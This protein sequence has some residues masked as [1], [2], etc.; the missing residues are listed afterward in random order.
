MPGSAA[1]DFEPETGTGFGSP[2]A[3][4]FEPIDESGNSLHRVLND[5]RE[6][7]AAAGRYIF[8][9]LEGLSHE[10]AKMLANPPPELTDVQAEEVLLPAD[11]QQRRVG[12]RTKAAQAAA[13]KAEETARYWKQRADQV[14]TESGIDPAL[15]QTWDA[16]LSRAAGPATGMVMESLI[17]F[18]GLPIMAMHG[19]AAAEAEAKNAG[20]TDEESE[21]AAVRSLIGLGIFGGANKV[22]ALGVAKLLPAGARTVTKFVSQFIGQDV[23]NE[24]SSR[25]INAWEA[26]SE[27][28]P[29]EKIA[30]ATKALTNTTLESTVLNGVY[31]TMGAAHAAGRVEPIPEGKMIQFEPASEVPSEQSRP[32]VDPNAVA[33]GNEAAARAITAIAPEDASIIAGEGR[34]SPSAEDKARARYYVEL[35]AETDALQGETGHEILDAVVKAGGLPSKQGNFR[36]SYGGE[37]DSL[38]EAFRDPSLKERIPLNKVFR[39]DAPSADELATRLRDRGFNVQSRENVT[40]L[41]DTRLRTGRPIFGQ[42]AAAEFYSPKAHEQDLHDIESESRNLVQHFQAEYGTAG[43]IFR[44]AGQAA[45]SAEIATGNAEISDIARRANERSAQLKQNREALA[46]EIESRGSLEEVTAEGITS[47]PASKYARELIA[48]YARDVRSGVVRSKPRYPIYRADFEHRPH[49][50]TLAADYALRSLQESLIRTGFRPKE[51]ILFSPRR[52]RGVRPIPPPAV[53]PG[54]VMTM[55]GR[56]PVTMGRTRAGSVSGSEVMDALK[57][58]MTTSG[59]A[60]EIRRGRFRTSMASGIFKSQP[61]IVRL[62]HIDNIPTAVHE[63]GHA[64]MKQFYG[65][66]KA[67]GLKW[68]P[69]A[70]RREL[71]GMGKEL[72]GNRKP[73]AGYSGEGFA[74]FIRYYLTTD[75]AAKVAPNTFKFFEEGVLVDHPEVATQL[76]AART[77]I[78]IY[79]NQGAVERANRQIVRDPGWTRRT[80]GALR[81]FFTLQKQVE[82]GVPLLE[83]SREAHRRSG[84]ALSPSEDPYKLFKMKRGSSG[85][86]M[87]RMVQNNMVD[88]WGNPTGP[89]LMEALAEVKGERNEFLLYLFARRAQERWSK[90][91]NPGI[92]KEDADYIRQTLESQRFDRAAVKYYKWWD[93]VLDYLAQADPAMADITLQIKQGSS[94]YAPLARML[95]ESAVRKQ[96]AMSQINP[97]YRMHGS[98]LPVKDIFDQTLLSATRLVN[99]ANRA[100]VTNAVVKLAQIDG[101]GRLLEE[102]PREQVRKQFNADQIRADLEKMGVDTSALPEDRILDYYTPADQPKGSDPIISAKLPDGSTHWYYVE[103]RTYDVLNKIEPFSFRSVPHV[104]FVLDLVLG[105][106][107]RLFTLGTTGLRPAFSLL[108]NPLRDPQGWLL[109]TKAGINPAKMAAAYFR[110]VGEQLR[111]AVGGKEGPLSNAA[112][113]LGAHMAQPLGRDIQ[114]TRRVSNELFH[115]RF[116]RLV[117][118]PVDHLRQLLSIPES[119]PRLAEF[120]RVADEIGWQPGREMS[121]DQA[122]RLALAFKEATVDFSASGDISRIVNEAVPFFNPSIQ[123]ART[124]VRAFRDHPLRTVMVGL[125]SFTAPALLLWWKNKDEDWYRNLPWRE[126]YYYTNIDDGKNVWQIPRAFEWGNLFGV[127]PEGILDSWY[128]QDP[129]AVKQALAHSFETQNPLDYPVAIRVAKEQWQNRIDFWNRPIIPRGEIDLVPGAQAG[130]YTTKVALWLG[131]TFPNQLSPRRIDAAVRGYFGGAVPDLLDSLGLGALKATGEGEMADTPVIGKLWRRGGAYNAQSQYLA[132]FWEIKQGVD[133]RAGAER[134]QEKNPDRAQTIDVDPRDILMA[135]SLDKVSKD[136]SDGLHIAGQMRESTERQQLYKY[137][138]EE[139]KMIVDL[140]ND[141]GENL[142]HR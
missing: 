94:D 28:P 121:P 122:V 119:F 102:V 66:V 116:M 31:A 139:A 67:R 96:A 3:I 33:A 9:G 62:E 83:L 32:V 38:E 15:A 20:K 63:T 26:A 77:L 88:L 125:G 127:L 50:Y 54:A 140:W 92:T 110:A 22:A 118:N 53:P 42:P 34:S 97:L 109:Q 124:A 106:P 71:I 24:A 12:E 27:A 78:D 51:D 4:S 68:V 43:E 11:E 60:G 45:P 105:A 85:A 58:V 41:L 73:I 95:D 30:A 115:G 10:Q 84:R 52:A 70:V 14:D 90:G 89:S 136:I 101:M 120:K 91:K 76:R 113:N 130:P 86:I 72:Y 46:R 112:Y 131:K 117:R 138:A 1:I 75:S 35:Q 40:A 134:L 55:D 107:K 142:A 64:L 44:K 59:G 8:H 99:R 17:P 48:D 57:R 65:T 132:D 93:G 135:R 126:R 74:E 80:L 23:A 25:A 128:R 21:S 69:S 82:S 47:G 61:E 141:Q 104:G 103:P 108:T 29:G 36:A 37:L 7:G 111:A 6:F 49:Q 98:G 133:A 79:R 5:V 19:A 81:E 39:S 18:A 114:H 56:L 2:T 100:L 87:E 137:I 129:E 123:G 16:R 13:P